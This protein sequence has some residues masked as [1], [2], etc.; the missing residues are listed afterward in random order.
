MRPARKSFSSRR[1]GA[2]PR[3][4]PGTAANVEPSPRLRSGTLSNVELC[5]GRG[6][7]KGRSCIFMRWGEEPSWGLC[8]A[9]GR[10][11]ELAEGYGEEA[12][13]GQSRGHVERL[14]EGSRAGAEARDPPT[15]PKMCK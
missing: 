10:G 1:D 8:E 3:P 12:L 7:A 2:C 11:H 14:G 9:R 13:L 15:P 4:G 6:G 5:L